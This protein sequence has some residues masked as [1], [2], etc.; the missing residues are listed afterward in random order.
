ML[1][2]KWP[3]RGTQQDPAIDEEESPL[4]TVDAEEPSREAHEPDVAHPWT[5]RERLVSIASTGAVWVFVLCGP[6]AL[7]T[8]VLR[9]DAPTTASVETQEVDVSQS[10]A[11]FGAGFMTQYLSTPRGQEDRITAM[12]AEGVDVSLALPQK[13]API[14]SVLPAEAV[15]ISE[16]QWL[17]SVTVEHPATDGESGAT[18]HW[19]VPV[20]TDD[21]GHRAV[22][23]LPSLVPEPTVGDLAVE[24]RSEVRDSDITQT[25]DA[26]MKAYL[27]GQGEVAPLT[28][29]EASL[30][31]V[32][33][34]PYA[35]AS[36]GA[37]LTDQE[38][39]ESPSEGDLLRTQISATATAVDGSTTQLGYT[40]ELRYRD[41]WEVS[42]VNPTTETPTTPEG[43]P[44]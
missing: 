16:T 41:R 5:N 35:E 17:V 38:V 13:P 20:E 18:R 30:T 36:V 27:A 29:P 42:A 39:P 44:S 21:A 15:A 8:S 33:P 11:T 14:S 31:A 24:S 12:L 28:T 10:V 22:S 26:F 9:E 4:E 2:L 23:A 32:S 43:D 1:S 40:V 37:V 3:R 25:L 7:A 6:L 34:T 19:Q